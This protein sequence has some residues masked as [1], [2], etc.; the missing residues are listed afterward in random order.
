MTEKRVAVVAIGG[1]SLIKDKSHQTV[2]D[3]Y[4]AAKETTHHIGEMIAQGW[5]DLFLDLDPERGLKAGE[6]WQAALKA[7]AERCQMVLFL[8]SPAWAASRWC[9]A[10]FLLALQMNKRIFGVIVEPTP[11][12]DLPN[13]MTAE[14][15]LVDLTAGAND[16]K[17]TVE[18]PFSDETATVTYTEDGLNRLKTGL[19]SAGLDPQY[20]P[21]P[22]QD[23]PEDLGD[24][25]W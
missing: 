19:L 7:A 16:Y 25:E 15:Q 4:L 24:G 9:L 13:E 6:R 22:P 10:E 14:W 20:F 3:Q 5:D 1:N 23:D 12:A 18:L 2:M 21:W 8:I 17:A 11:L